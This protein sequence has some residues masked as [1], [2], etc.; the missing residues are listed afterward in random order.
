MKH[1]Y[2][3]QVDKDILKYILDHPDKYELTSIYQNGVKNT[4]KDGVFTLIRNYLNAL[5]EEGKVS[6][7]YKQKG[8]AG[9]LWGVDIGITNICKKVRHTIASKFNIDIDIMNCH[10]VFLQHYCNVNGIPTPLLDDYILNRIDIITRYGES[11]KI[12]VLKSINGGTPSMHNDFIDKFSKE[13]LDIRNQVIVLESSLYKRIKRKKAYNIEGGVVN[14]IM[15]D[16]ENKS[17]NCM[18]KYLKKQKVK[19]TSLAYD[20]LT[21]EKNKSNISRLPEILLGCERVIL[22]NLDVKVRVLEKKMDK[23]YAI[24]LGTPKITSP[25]R[26]FRDDS[27]RCECAVDHSDMFKII[28]FIRD[29]FNIESF[30]K[31]FK[32]MSLFLSNYSNGRCLRTHIIKLSRNIEEYDIVELEEFIKRIRE[33]DNSNYHWGWLKSFVSPRSVK[34]AELRAIIN[35]QLKESKDEEPRE[36][37]AVVSN[38]FKD[39][40]DIYQL[41]LEYRRKIFDS[42]DELIEDFLSKIDRYCKSVMLP[43]CYVTNQDE[44][45]IE[46]V[47]LKD[48]EINTR[49]IWYDEEKKKHISTIDVLSSFFRNDLNVASKLPFYKRVTFQ[50]NKDHL[51]SGELNMFTG[52]RAQLVDEIKPDLIYPILHHI[53]TC[54]ADD[55]E[56]LYNYIIHWFKMCFLKPWEKTGIVLLLFGL[57]GTG[58]GILI[59]NL[60]IP[61]IYGSKISCVS[62]GLGPITQRFNSICMNKLFI[63][64][65]EVSS[66]EGFH[67]TFDRL[68]AI[69]TDKTISIEKKGIDIFKD[70]PNYINFMFTTNNMQSVKLGRTDRRYCCLETSSRYKGDFDY[71]DTLLSSCNQEVA[72]HF[73]TYCINYKK[74]RN[75]RNIPM[76]PLKSDMMLNSKTSVEKFVDCVKELASNTLVKPAQCVF[77][78][79]MK[80]DEM[81]SISLYH[82]KGRTPSRELYASYKRWCKENN[83]KIKSSTMFGREANKLMKR[84]RDSKGIF[85]DLL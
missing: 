62:Q 24:T 71:F 17:L 84:G 6:I 57:E 49:Y 66:G 44:G 11:I 69:I 85:Y 7:E 47:G 64:A 38:D 72:N 80:W 9:R 18:I 28:K 2:E 10:P 53:K 74:T 59:D 12:E 5:D 30:G 68:K 56:D 52:F 63:C 70:Y 42:K 61:F 23:G 73:F 65:N 55:D 41:T 79:D 8:G 46:I 36:Y 14:W 31:H 1:L 26:L 45:N 50:P 39:G 40:Y 29:H 51:K 60:I 82:Y 54:W 27:K 48:L 3:Q 83:E 58:K 67:N 37:D 20:G 4:D 19:I 76:T 22:D 43:G 78:D 25:L 13:C 81:L 16:M 35:E 32:Q 33:L 15:V 75:I 77:V 34:H 21:I